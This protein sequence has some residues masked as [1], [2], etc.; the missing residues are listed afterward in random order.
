MKLSQLLNRMVSRKSNTTD[1]DRVANLSR[2]EQSRHH[3]L[4][5]EARLERSL[6]LMK[7]NRL[8]VTTIDTNIYTLLKRVTG[9]AITFKAKEPLVSTQFFSEYHTIRLESFFVDSDGFYISVAELNKLVIA[10]KM[11][12]SE[13]DTLKE[14]DPSTFAY[15]DRLLTKTFTSIQNI[16][17]AILTASQ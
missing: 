6:D 4:K 12:F 3:L 11:M 7:A 5:M 15:A 1:D 10:C 14:K 2:M 17:I 9:Y 8:L 16:S 13:L